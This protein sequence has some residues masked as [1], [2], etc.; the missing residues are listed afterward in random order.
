[1]TLKKTLCLV[2]TLLLTIVCAVSCN[3]QEDPGKAT[4]TK[5]EIDPLSIATDC[6]V[7][8]TINTSTIKAIA[9]YSDGTIKE[10]GA[11]S[12]TVV[13]QP[14]TTTAGQTTLTVS[15]GGKNASIIITVNENTFTSISISGLEDY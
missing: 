12:L 13:A 2:L 10:I 1:M 7:G 11:D 15:Y 8:G 3:P 14:D 4:L 6:Y 9:T 5:L